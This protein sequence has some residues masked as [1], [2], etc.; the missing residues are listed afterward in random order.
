MS[1]LLSDLRGRQQ[2]YPKPYTLCTQE[3][4]AHLRYLACDNAGR[5]G[6]HL[7]PRS[8]RTRLHEAVGSWA[9]W[10]SY[11]FDFSSIELKM[12]G[13]FWEFGDA[14]TPLTCVLVQP[15]VTPLS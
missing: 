7:E 1:F 8:K 2:A 15:W 11:L 13:M 5:L 3:D 14:S 12:P 4:E 9:R 10:P 6:F